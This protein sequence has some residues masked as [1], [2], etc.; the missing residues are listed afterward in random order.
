MHKLAD[1][2]AVKDP[3]AMYQD[4]GASLEAADGGGYWHG[5][6]TDTSFN[7]PILVGQTFR[8]H[9]AHDVSR[10]R[11]LPSDDILTKL[12][13]AAMAVSL[14]T[15]VPLLDHHVV[16]YAWR[17]PLTMKIRDGQGKW[18]LR[19]V[20]YRYVPRE[21][22]E[23]PKKGLEF[24]SIHGCGGPCVSG[25]KHCWMPIVFSGRDTFILVHPETMGG[26]SVWKAQLAVCTLECVDVSGVE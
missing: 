5:R 17:L 25:P 1:L 9:D 11:R 24:R 21:L 20:L 7:R 13:R 23:R 16:E 12:D 3:D 26:A 15:R 8:V 4:I 14:E 10:P 2:L 22:I 18:L 6:T 19:Q